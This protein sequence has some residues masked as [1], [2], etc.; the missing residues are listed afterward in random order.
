MWSLTESLC[1]EVLTKRLVFFGF[2]VGGWVLL[3]SLDAVSSALNGSWWS[4]FCLIDSSY[5]ES[6]SDDDIVVF[7]VTQWP[8]SIR[9]FVLEEA[10]SSLLSGF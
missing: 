9:N 8:A 10:E 7:L 3:K 4:Y 1:C 5:F 6:C 2:G